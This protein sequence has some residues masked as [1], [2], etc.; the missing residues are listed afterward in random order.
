VVRPFFDDVPL[1]DDRPFLAVSDFGPCFAGWPGSIGG[2]RPF[3]A[4]E[5][6]RL[7]RPQCRAEEPNERRA[8][9]ACRAAPLPT[10]SV[11]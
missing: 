10:I 6:I 5:R 3:S 2:S 4:T 11:P 7:E 8:Q 9:R 1:S